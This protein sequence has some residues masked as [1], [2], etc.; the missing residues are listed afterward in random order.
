MYKYIMYVSYQFQNKIVRFV[1]SVYARK[2]FSVLG[3]LN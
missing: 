3:V 2:Y 1:I